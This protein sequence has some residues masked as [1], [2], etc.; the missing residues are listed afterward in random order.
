[1][2]QRKPVNRLG[3]KGFEEIKQHPWFQNFDWMRLEKKEMLSP[4][5]PDVTFIVGLK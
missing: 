2:I 3:S 1:L 5:I 4:F